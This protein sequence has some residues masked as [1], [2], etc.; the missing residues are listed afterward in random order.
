VELVPYA[1]VYPRPN[2]NPR[3]TANAQSQRIYHGL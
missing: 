2:P 1:T 3:K